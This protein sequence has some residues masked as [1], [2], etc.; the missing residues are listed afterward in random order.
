M[1]GGFG[2]GRVVTPAQSA[3]SEDVV[4]G[5]A[6]EDALHV[7]HIVAGDR[8]LVGAAGEGGFKGKKRGVEIG[9]ERILAAR[10]VIAGPGGLPAA[11]RGMLKR[12]EYLIERAVHQVHERIGVAER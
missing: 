6:G 7:V 1:G 3:K 10:A 8:R 4:A 11:R 12:L 5:Y 9:D 2:V